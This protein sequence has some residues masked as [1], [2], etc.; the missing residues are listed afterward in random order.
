VSGLSFR[1]LF[2]Y[3]PA[4]GLLTCH[5]RVW[6]LPLRS[7]IAFPQFVSGSLLPAQPYREPLRLER[8][9]GSTEDRS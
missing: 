7:P 6:F 9:Y 3:P 1:S 8:R 5:F 2:I 4:R